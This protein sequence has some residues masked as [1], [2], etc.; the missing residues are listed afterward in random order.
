MYQQMILLLTFQ[1]M[2]FLFI[3]SFSKSRQKGSIKHSN[4][5]CFVTLQS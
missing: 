3:Q 2:T 4:V 5:Y 1:K